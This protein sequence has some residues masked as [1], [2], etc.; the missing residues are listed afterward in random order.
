MLRIIVNQF[1]CIQAYCRDKKLLTDAFF[2]SLFNGDEKFQ[3][4][5]Y[6]QEDMES[7]VSHLWHYAE[8]DVDFDVV[9]HTFNPALINCLDD[10]QAEKSILYYEAGELKPVFVDMP[11]MLEKLVLMGP[12]DAVADTVFPQEEG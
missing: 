8:E 4:T 1:P 6:R 10:W 9:V 12:G 7:L 3:G 11:G 5:A 2:Y